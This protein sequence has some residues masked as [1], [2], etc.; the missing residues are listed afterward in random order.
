VPT[1]RRNRQDVVLLGWLKAL[2]DDAVRRS[3]VLSVFY[4]DLL[5]AS[6]DLEGVEPRLVDAERALSAVS[7][8]ESPPWADT[9]EL[10][11]LPATIA[12]YRASLAQ[13]RGDVAGTAEHARRALD[14]AGPT[15]HLARGG[16]AG[17]LGL[18][19]WANGDVSSALQTFTQAVASLHAAGNLIDELSSTVVLADLWL[20]AGRPSRARRLYEAALQ[21]AETHGDRVARATADL[22]V[23]ISEIDVEVGDFESADR[24]LEAA[25]ALRDRSAVSER[26][27]RWFVA[28]GLLAQAY[29]QTEDA[30]ELL[31]QAA[32]L[33]RSGFFPDVRPIAAMKA[34][35]WISRGN[36]S[37]AA[38]WADERG[39]SAADDA[40][41]L[42][43]FDHLTFVRLLIARYRAD[44]DIGALEQ[45]APLLDRLAD[46]AEN[47]GRAG[48]LI[49]IRM[50]Q[51]LAHD[52]QGHRVQALR[53]LD[54]A[55]ARAP[56]PEGYVR[57]FL[58]EG[59]PMVELLRAAE[60]LRDAVGHARRLLSLG[61]DRGGEAAKAGQRMGLS[62]AEPSAGSLS[63]RELQVLRLLD[64][65]L[66]GPQIAHQLFVSPNTLRTHTKHIFTKLDV[67]SRRAAVRRAREQGL[68]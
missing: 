23:G 29:G 44:G 48:S 64:S 52:A 8:G 11:T 7:D 24:H 3:P 47:S 45:A 56:E 14:L 9:E 2:P 68:I 31:N 36:L 62:L 66:T 42:S 13:A 49:E 34:R 17:F 5:M 67:T 27:Y 30:V 39:V 20:A 61:A 6:G 22:H 54:Q 41:Y 15:E 4:G 25:A 18:A 51:A 59:A 28:M 33:Y 63:D 10:R 1:L 50:L 55:W 53:S 19:A 12:I 21:L 43:E 40:S 57:L 46:N 32:Q 16:A 65:E 26:R 58:D 37:H 60:P 35:F 38:D